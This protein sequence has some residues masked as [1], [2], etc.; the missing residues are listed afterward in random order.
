MKTFVAAM[1]RGG[2][3]LLMILVILLLLL[4]FGGEALGWERKT[5][6]LGSVGLL[7][8][9]LGVV[10][11]QR[12]LAFKSALLIEQASSTRPSPPSSSRGSAR[13]PSTPCPGT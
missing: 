13:A 9:G 12:F 5:R 4:W 3:T 7:F 2:G 10:V 6:I 1:S 8:A 11:V